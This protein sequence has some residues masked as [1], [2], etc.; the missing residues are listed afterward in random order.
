MTV[1]IWRV[2]SGVS[3]KTVIDRN[4]LLPFYLICEHK[5]RHEITHMTTKVVQFVVRYIWGN[6]RAMRGFEL[7]IS[8]FAPCEPL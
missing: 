2:P 3:R 6:I 7:Y 4:M 1:Q 8:I 5:I